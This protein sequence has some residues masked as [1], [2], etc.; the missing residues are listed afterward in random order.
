V[1]TDWSLSKTYIHDGQAI[2]YDVFGEGKPVVCIHGTPFSSYVWRRIAPELARDRKVHVFDL[3][4]YG[5]SEK[6]EGQDVSLGVQNGALAALLRHWGLDRPKVIAHDFGGATALRAHLLNG[7]DYEKLLLVDPVSI[8]PWGSPFVQHVR[9]HEEAFAGV[10]DYLQQAIL[11]AY[12]RSAISRPISD[13]ELEPYLAPW[14]GPVGQP[15]FYRQIAQMDMKYTDEVQD[16]YGEIRC[17]V[18]LL[19]GKEDQWLPPERGRELAAMIPNCQLYEIPGSG[20]LMQED[21]PEAI[22]S[23][24]LRFFG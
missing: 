20:H 19:W 2:A 5:Q 21:A 3:L 24:A 16:R 6:A 1:S 9:N 8:R 13:A 10:P 4:G 12:L 18:V 23:A 22:V 11:R 14:L 17:P 15:A 7:C